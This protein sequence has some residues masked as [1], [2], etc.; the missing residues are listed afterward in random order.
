MYLTLIN[1]L[2][3]IVLDIGE[4]GFLF[5]LDIC[6]VCIFS[7]DTSWLG[8]AAPILAIVLIRKFLRRK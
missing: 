7:V 5:S 6:R 1:K 4:N 3:E 8:V 2:V